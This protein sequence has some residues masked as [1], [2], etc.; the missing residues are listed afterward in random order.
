MNEPEPGDGGPV[1][2]RKIKI[3]AKKFADAQNLANAGKGTIVY[4]TK[5]NGNVEGY[6][7]QGNLESKFN[8]RKGEYQMVDK[9]TGK[10]AKPVVKIKY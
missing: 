7:S 10:K 8:D 3:K 6:A 5:K 9:A 2:P 4:G 1:K